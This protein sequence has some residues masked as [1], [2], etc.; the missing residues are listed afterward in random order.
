MSWIFRASLIVL[1]LALAWPAAGPVTAGPAVPS[2]FPL[3]LNAEW[4]RKNDDNSLSTSKVTGPKTIGTVRC[5]VIERKFTFQGRERVER[6]CYLATATEV[7][8]IETTSQRGEPQTLKPPR[9]LLK[10][11][12]KA[13]QTWSWSPEDPGV[14]LKI[15]SKWIGEETLKVGAGQFKAWK[16]ETITTGEDLDIKAY[17]WYAPGAGTIRNERNGHRGERKISGW[18]ELV[19][20]KIP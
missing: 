13:G 7:V 18:T 17:T 12:P 19:S 10:L 3:V 6:N 11:P 9:T 8:L 16:I 5:V 14:D 2:L 20:Y 1:A 15:T 4:T